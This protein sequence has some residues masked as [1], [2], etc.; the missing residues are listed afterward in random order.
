MMYATNVYNT[1]YNSEEICVYHW[2]I[3]IDLNKMKENKHIGKSKKKIITTSC[4][5]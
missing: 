4:H 2:N 5:F 1:N 3:G